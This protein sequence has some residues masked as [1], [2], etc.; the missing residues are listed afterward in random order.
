MKYYDVYFSVTH[1][2]VFPVKANSASEAHKAFY[3][4]WNNPNSNVNELVL[5]YEE[6]QDVTSIE[7]LN[8]NELGEPYW[9]E[10]NEN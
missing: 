9:E 3:D 4:W 2:Y 1:E 7:V 6:L 10:A 8:E 5:S